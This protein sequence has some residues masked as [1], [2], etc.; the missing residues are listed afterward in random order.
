[1][2]TEDLQILIAQHF[3]YADSG[4]FFSGSYFQPKHSSSLEMLLE[5]LNR[6]NMD[7]VTILESEKALLEIE[8]DEL[9]KKNSTV[10]AL[11]QTIDKLRASVVNA[12][13]ALEEGE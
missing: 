10:E 9:T 4:Q 2:K 1:M 13:A 3:D 7:R 11:E 12:K 6:E 8:C 5:E